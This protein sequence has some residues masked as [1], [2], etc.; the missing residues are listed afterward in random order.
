M[1]SY[2][3][4][5]QIY[6]EIFCSFWSL[7]LLDPVLGSSSFGRDLTLGYESGLGF[8]R[9]ACGSSSPK[10]ESLYRISPNVF[11]FLSGRRDGTFWV[12]PVT[13]GLGLLV[14]RCLRLALKFLS[15]FA[16]EVLV[17]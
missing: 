12:I 1:L 4:K 3:T 13:S 2:S 15:E 5:R 9:L 8:G 10:W 17:L 6:D 16:V 7:Q 14:S 11:L